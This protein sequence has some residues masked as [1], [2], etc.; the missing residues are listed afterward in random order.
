MFVPGAMAATSAQTAITN[1]AEAPRA[2]EG[3][4]NTATGV[5]ARSIRSTICRIELSRPPGVSIRMITSGAD[6]ASARSMAWTTC[7]ALTAWT[8]PSSSTTGISARAVAAAANA[9]E[10]A[11]AATRLRG[12]A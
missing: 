12:M 1:P 5:F 8:T 6:A 4:T 10:A 2:P 11:K 3:A 7:A 9:R